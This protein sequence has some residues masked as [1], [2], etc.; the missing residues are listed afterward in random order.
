VVDHALDV[1]VRTE[2]TEILYRA[3]SFVE[4]ASKDRRDDLQLLRAYGQEWGV[5]GFHRARDLRLVCACLA[6][7]AVGDATSL[8]RDL[9]FREALR[10]VQPGGEIARTL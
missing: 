3:T 1:R 10:I 8:E 2:E 6:K 4:T 7:V 9:R 5:R